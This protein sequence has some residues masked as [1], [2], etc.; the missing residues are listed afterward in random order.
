MIIV[1]IGAV[2]KKT[3]TLFYQIITSDKRTAVSGVHFYELQLKCIDRN[4]KCK[5]WKLKL[6]NESSK[7]MQIR[8]AKGLAKY[9][10]V[11]FE[12]SIQNYYNSKDH[13]ILKPLEFTVQNKDYYTLFGEKNPNKQKQKMQSVV[14]IQDV[15]NVLHDAYCYF[16]AIESKLPQKYAVSQT[17]QEIDASMEN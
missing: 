17:Y 4:Y 12:N 6:H 5:S 13:I 7:I 15:E 16:A 2:I 14:R 1:I 9:I 8:H 11:N 3:H 10:Q